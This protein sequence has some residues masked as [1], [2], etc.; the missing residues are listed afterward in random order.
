MNRCLLVCALLLALLSIASC[1]SHTDSSGGKGVPPPASVRVDEAPQ[2]VRVTWSGTKHAACYTVFWG[3]SPTEYRNFANTRDCPVI[4]SGLDKGELYCFAVTAWGERGESDYSM[5]VMYVYD[6]DPSRSTQHLTKGN[7][8]MASGQ[9]PEAYAYIS[10]AIRL[11]P[12]RAEAYKSRALLYERMD[13]PELAKKDSVMAEKL[14][15]RKT[16]SLHLS[17]Q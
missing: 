10:A 6:D 13:E 3:S 1:S 17:G 5:E 11:Q 15:S 14:S 16:A 12:Q 9:Y 4:I 8:L 7:E 2:G